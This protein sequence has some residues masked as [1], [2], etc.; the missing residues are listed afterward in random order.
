MP[1]NSPPPITAPDDL[2]R[3]PIIQPD[4]L[5]SVPLVPIETHG[6]AVG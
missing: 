5:Y 2:Y 4:D 6:G 3:V 1:S